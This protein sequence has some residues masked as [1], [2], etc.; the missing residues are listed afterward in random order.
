MIVETEGVILHGMNYRDT[1]KIVTVYTKKFGKIKVVAKG[2]RS[3]KNKFGSSLEPMT[4]ASIVLY[5]KE[6]KDLHL[7]SKSEIAVVLNRLQENQ[8]RMY[9]GLAVVE[10]VSMVMHDEDGNGKVY[11]LL[12]ESLTAV[13]AA[14]KNHVNVLLSF[15]MKLFGELGF[16]MNLQKCSVCQKSIDELDVTHAFLRLSDGT[17]TCSDCTG[18]LQTNGTKVSGGMLKSLYYLQ[19]NEIKQ[20]SSLALSSNVKND[21]I[22]TLESYLRYH[23]EGSRTL[24]SLSLLYS[25]Q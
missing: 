16:G 4:I 24:K 17:M 18:D 14:E 9:C 20:A 6:H 10:L 3:Q 25:T 5:K 22:A 2:V 11:E 8:E 15:M 12:T 1:S 19:E 13:N 21:L 23:S 7:L